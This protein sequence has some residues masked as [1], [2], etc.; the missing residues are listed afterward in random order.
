MNCPHCKETIKSGATRCPFCAREIS[1]ANKFTL[2]RLALYTG[3]IFAIVLWLNSG[4]EGISDWARIW[5]AIKAAVIGGPIL[6]LF[7][8]KIPKRRGD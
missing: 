2:H 5:T 1:Y 8:D 6:W 3:G 4:S 7:S